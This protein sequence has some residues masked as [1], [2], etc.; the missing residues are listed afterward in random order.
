MSERSSQQRKLASVESMASKRRELLF[1]SLGS[2]GLSP[3]VLHSILGVE[4]LES[5][6]QKPDGMARGMQ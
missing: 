2:D 4:I 1:L 5:V 6:Q 3:G